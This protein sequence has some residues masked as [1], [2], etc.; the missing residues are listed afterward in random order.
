[1]D[2]K[3]E[4]DDDTS[5]PPASLHSSP[6][7][8]PRKQRAD[9][10]VAVS[11]PSDVKLP[12]TSHVAAPS[13]F[14]RPEGVD[15]PPTVAGRKLGSV[16][17]ALVNKKP[18]REAEE[19]TLPASQPKKKRKKDAARDGEDD[20]TTGRSDARDFGA[21]AFV[22]MQSADMTVVHPRG[23]PG[24]I[25]PDLRHG[26]ARGQPGRIRSRTT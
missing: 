22:Q 24:S 13:G 3:P 16:A 25:R 20:Y 2:V 11:A 15:A 10:I 12:P 21:R 19:P 26:C 1:M 5:Q 17:A 6:K 9:A 8:K 14:L 23:R 4:S 18:K 7:P